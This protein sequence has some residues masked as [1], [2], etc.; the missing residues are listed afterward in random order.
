MKISVIAIGLAIALGLPLAAEAAGSCGV[1]QGYGTSNPYTANR[2]TCGFDQDGAPASDVEQKAD[3]P[4][5]S[6][7]R[8]S[9][10]R[11]YGTT[12]PYIPNSGAGDL[13]SNSSGN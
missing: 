12:N 10:P 8:P 6:A 13:G 7:A 5:D 2:S 9:K 3:V 11:G 1:P 4:A